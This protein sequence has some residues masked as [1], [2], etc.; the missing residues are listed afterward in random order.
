MIPSYVTNCYCYCYCQHDILMMMMMM[1]TTSYSCDSFLLFFFSLSI[2]PFSLSLSHCLS[3]D[4]F[5]SLSNKLFGKSICKY[6]SYEQ[7]KVRWGVEACISLVYC[8]IG[9]GTQRIQRKI[10]SHRYRRFHWI[11]GMIIDPIWC[12]RFLSECVMTPAGACDCIPI[13]TS[14]QKG[15]A[16]IG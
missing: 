1:E 14:N 5:F 4:L 7:K 9:G 3:A 13:K 15:E 8:V 12:A 10:R 16:I 6:V 2:L 11:A